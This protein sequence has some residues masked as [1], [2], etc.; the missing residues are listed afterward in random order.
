MYQKAICEYFT[1]NKNNMIESLGRLVAINSVK[2][3][4]KPG[5]PFGEGPAA[6]LEEGIAICEELGL[7]ARN[8]EGYV[9]CADLNDHETR[10]H[11]LGHLDIVG[12]GDGWDTPPFELTEK[13]GCLYG[14][15]TD[16]DKG[17]VIAA[18]YAMKAIKDLEI[19]MEY[20]VRLIMGTDE[21]SGSADIAYYY[22]KQ[23]HAPY[24]FSPDGDFPVVN[25]EKGSFRPKFSRKFIKTSV[26]PRL[27]Q[28]SGGERFNVVPASARALIEGLTKAEL[29]AYAA[30]G[31]PEDCIWAI[32]DEKC[33]RVTGKS[34]HASTPDEGANA[35]TALIRILSLMPLA[36][37]DSSD[38]IAALNRLL[39]HGDLEGNAL[40][41][42]QKD[43]LSGTLTLAFSILE[44]N[45]D[46]MN[47][48]FDSRVPICATEKNCQDVA[49]GALEAAGFDC[50][51][52]Q[53]PAHHTPEDSAFIQTLLNCYEQYTGRKG[54][55]LAIGGGTYVH[56]IEGGVAF[57]AAMP[58]FQS[59]LHG[60]NERL[61]IE[62]WITAAEIFTQVMI[63]L[64]GKGPGI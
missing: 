20:N 19:P 7:Q 43:E 63:D 54:E 38:A 30:T 31:C 28:I 16:D 47:G 15:G 56:D 29:E 22:E 21:E 17:P 57:G 50:E 26:F 58:D 12:A 14:R 36:P 40:G 49:Q 24:T 62:D 25:I 32:D 41:I 2:G 11:I 60:A 8:L 64:C 42:A 48:I 59:N 1:H 27:V 46:G 34:A 23:P 37:C 18:L 53:E 3:E 51:G 45:E 10:L 35:I 39:P 55:C 6:C 44:L 13:D 5:K 9:G 33:L 61:R 4:E 52:V